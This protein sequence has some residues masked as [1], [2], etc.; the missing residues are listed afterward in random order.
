MISGDSV[1]PRGRGRGRGHTSGRVR[2]R[3][4]GRGFSRGGR[5][6]GNWL[7]RLKDPTKGFG[8]VLTPP[9]ITL[10]SKFLSSAIS[11][12]AKLFC[13]TAME[14]LDRHLQA[15]DLPKSRIGGFV[16]FVRRFCKSAAYGF[17][18]IDAYKSC[19]IMK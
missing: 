16:F 17:T 2:G 9:T 7:I 3:G 14:K 8:S 10:E 15:C 4:R 13:E 18:R 1:T 11:E 6:R 12:H 19:L 5:G